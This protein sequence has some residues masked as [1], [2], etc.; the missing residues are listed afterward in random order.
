MLLTD[1]FIY[2]F[3]YF[4]LCINVVNLLSMIMIIKK[5][6]SNDKNWV[7]GGSLPAFGTFLKG[8]SKFKNVF[9]RHVFKVNNC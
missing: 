2:L 6:Q 1:L 4:V 8:V 3:F 9:R 7:A 5:A